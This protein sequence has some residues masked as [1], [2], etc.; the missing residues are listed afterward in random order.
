MAFFAM[1]NFKN[2]NKYMAFLAMW[3]FLFIFVL[4]EKYH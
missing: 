4:E 3:A 1:L 2:I